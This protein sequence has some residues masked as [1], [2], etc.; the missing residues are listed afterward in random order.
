M[1][2]VTTFFLQVD[3]GTLFAIIQAANYLDVK[4]LLDSSCKY[5]ASLIK[6]KNPEEIRKICNIS[7]ESNKKNEEST[8]AK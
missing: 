8:E 5:L 2:L 6:G 4:G 3:K 7:V 1:K